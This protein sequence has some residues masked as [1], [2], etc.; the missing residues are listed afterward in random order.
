M[1]D[2]VGRIFFQCFDGSKLFISNRLQWSVHVA[3]LEC[4]SQ[5]TDGV[6]YVVLAIVG[7]D[8]K[9]MREK[10]NSVGNSFSPGSRDVCPGTSVVVWVV[11]NIP[12]IDTMLIPSFALLWS[13]IN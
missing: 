9:A 11:P 12:S 13:F 3:V 7:W 6:G 4:I 8:C 2:G 5:I 10:G 1:L